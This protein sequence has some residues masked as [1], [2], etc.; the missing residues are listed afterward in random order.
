MSDQFS[1][2]PSP[3]P[4][5]EPDELSSLIASIVKTPEEIAK[6]AEEAQHQPACKTRNTF[7]HE[8]AAQKRNLRQ[9][10]PEYYKLYNTRQNIKRQLAKHANNPEKVAYY[11]EA[12]KSI[13]E[14]MNGCVNRPPRAKTY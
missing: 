14:Q 10:Y 12:L 6:E 11:T 1:A 2:P 13:N 3:T 9:I 8:E 5:N 4:T 7:T